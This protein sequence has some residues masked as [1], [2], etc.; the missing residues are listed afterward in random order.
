MSAFSFPACAVSYTAASTIALATS[1]VLPMSFESRASDCLYAQIDESFWPFMS[2]VAPSVF[3]NAAVLGNR[4][5][6]ACP[7]K[8][9]CCV[10]ETCWAAPIA[11]FTRPESASLVESR[12]TC[13]TKPSSAQRHSSPSMQSRCLN[14]I[15]RSS[16]GFRA[17]PSSRIE[18]A[19]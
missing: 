17:S 18:T 7:K 15:S 1:S 11:A 10:S 5:T 12:W 14:S 9:S 6:A 16:L 4:L 13:V 8:R 2:N 19:R 3:Q